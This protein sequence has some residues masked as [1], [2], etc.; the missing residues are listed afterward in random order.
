MKKPLLRH[1]KDKNSKTIYVNF[2][3]ELVKLL[4]ESKYFIFC[5]IEIPDNPQAIYS[6]VDRYRKMIV[7]QNHVAKRRGYSRIAEKF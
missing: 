7:L 6:Q 1:D 3:P 2:D 5:G 4:R